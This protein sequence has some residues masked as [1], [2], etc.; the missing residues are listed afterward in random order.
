[1]KK[2]E[3]LKKLV[4]EN[5]TEKMKRLLLLT[6]KYLEGLDR[7]FND[8]DVNGDILRNFDLPMFIDEL[9]EKGTL[10]NMNAMNIRLLIMNI[11]YISRHTWELVDKRGIV[12]NGDDLRKAWPEMYEED[13]VV[14]VETIFKIMKSM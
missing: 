9:R 13:E 10:K 1:M 5:G 7:M 8:R 6:E 12:K 3:E 4:E 2:I 11:Y 14:D